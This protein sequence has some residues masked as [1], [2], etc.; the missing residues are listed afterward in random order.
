MSIFGWKK[1]LQCAMESSWAISRANTELVSNVSYCLCLY[2]LGSIQLWR[3]SMQCQILTLHW[4]AD[5]MKRLLWIESLWKLQ[6]LCTPCNVFILYS[7]CNESRLFHKN[8]ISLQNCDAEN[9]HFR[10]TKT[11]N[12]EYVLYPSGKVSTVVGQ[13]SN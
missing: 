8:N 1:T 5:H 7:F 3:P 9:Y 12:P 11:R 6:I 4:H 10:C 2:H 13:T